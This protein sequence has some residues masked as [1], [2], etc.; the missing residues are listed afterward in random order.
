MFYGCDRYPECDFAV[1]NPPV[2]D[3]PCPEC[4]SLVVERPKSFRCWNCGAEMDKE[5]NVTRS[6]DPEAEAAARAAKAV[7]RA[8]RAAA[9]AARSKKKPTAKKKSTAKRKTAKKAT[10][11]APTATSPSADVPAAAEG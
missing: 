9:K 2:K 11:E 1:N 4:G 3:R 6:G 8:E 7:A 10:K 5:W